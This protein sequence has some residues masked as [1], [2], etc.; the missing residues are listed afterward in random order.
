MAPLERGRSRTSSVSRVAG[1]RNGVASKQTHWVEVPSREVSFEV[2][3]PRAWP[4][5][6]EVVSN[7]N[8]RTKLPL[9]EVGLDEGATKKEVD[10]NAVALNEVALVAFNEVL[11]RRGSLGRRCP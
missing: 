4:A 2:G 7:K 9:S 6:N 8:T 1:P 3:K 10:S 11:S 5:S